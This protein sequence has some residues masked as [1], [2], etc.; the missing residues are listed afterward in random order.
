MV[1]IKMKLD[2][3]KCLRYKKRNIIF[4]KPVSCK[5][6]DKARINIGGK[7]T[8][9]IRSNRNVKNL[10]C[11]YLI[12]ADNSKLIITDSFDV[13]SGCTI[14]ILDNAKLSI[15]SGY[16]NYN[17]KIYCFKEINIGRNVAI[18]EGVIIRDSDNHEILDGK[19]VKSKSINIGNDVWIGLNAIILN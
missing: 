4:Y 16:M 6:S 1:K 8:I 2:I 13:F 5:I 7:L 19:H 11:G 15:G 14:G 10:S 9:N 18:S 3:L 17:S 12:M